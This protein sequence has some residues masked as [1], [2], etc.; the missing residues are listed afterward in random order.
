MQGSGTCVSRILF[1]AVHLQESRFDLLSVDLTYHLHVYGVL[2]PSE[3]SRACCGLRVK[4]THIHIQE[5]TEP[6]T[7]GC[8]KRCFLWM[9]G[10][11]PLRNR[12]GTWGLCKDPSS[13]FSLFFNDGYICFLTESSGK[14]LF[15]HTR[16][17]LERFKSIVCLCVYRRTC[18]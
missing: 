8:A 15:I 17:F 6:W 1:R 16:D 18:F 11:S 13:A 4:H 3:I 10:K 7:V 9:E 14:K 5:W 12:A 2:K